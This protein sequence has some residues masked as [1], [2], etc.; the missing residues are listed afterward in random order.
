MDLIQSDRLVNRRY[1]Q[2]PK[3]QTKLLEGDGA[4][5][6]NLESSPQGLLN[7]PNQILNDIKGF[8][9]RKLA[10][11]ASTQESSATKEAISSK[12]DDVAAATPNAQEPAS[13]PPPNTQDG[14][15]I[16]WSDSNHGEADDPAEEAPRKKTLATKPLSPPPKHDSPVLPSAPREDEGGSQLH[17]AVPSSSIGNDDD[18]EIEPPGHLS[19]EIDFPVNRGALRAISSS[20]PEPTPPSAQIPTATVASTIQTG[21]SSKSRTS[22]ETASAAQDDVLKNAAIAALG[23]SKW[24]STALD[25]NQKSSTTTTSSGPK[26]ASEK[27]SQTSL[28]PSA[29]PNPSE[30]KSKSS[31]FTATWEGRRGTMPSPHLT[32]MGILGPSCG[33]VPPNAQRAQHGVA[34][35]TPY[36]EFKAAYS[37]YPESARKFVTGC[38]GVKQVMLDRAL[39][40]FL[41]DD[42]V[43]VYTTDFLLYVSE[44]NRKK[45]RKI[46]PA[47][48]WYNKFVK[49]PQYMKKIIRKDN[50]EAI[51]EAHSDDVRAIKRSFGGSQSTDSDVVI[52]DSDEE[53]LDASVEEATN[54]EDSEF[55][56]AHESQPS[57]E[58]HLESPKVTPIRKASTHGHDRSRADREKALGV[59]DSL[60]GLKATSNSNIQSKRSPVERLK[61]HKDKSLQQ[62]PDQPPSSSRA[63]VKSASGG[64]KVASARSQVSDVTPRASKTPITTRKLRSTSARTV[65]SSSGGSIATISPIQRRQLPASSP[66]EVRNRPSE[67]PSRSG[68]QQPNLPADHMPHQSEHVMSSSRKRPLASAINEADDEDEDDDAFDPPVNKLMPPPPKRP[69]TCSRNPRLSDPLAVVNMTPPSKWASSPAASTAAGVRDRKSFPSTMPTIST[70]KTPIVAP[71]TVSASSGLSGKGKGQVQVQVQT[72]TPSSSRPNISTAV[73]QNRIVSATLSSERKL[74]SNSASRPMKQQP[75]TFEDPAARA[76]RLKKF[77]RRRSLG[78]PSSSAATR[79]E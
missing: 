35:L 11:L 10:K 27:A 45:R 50:L 59:F 51:L 1:I 67:T 48:Q 74:D 13:S 46:L 61:T 63:H 43:R 78:T 5:Y 47:V 79:K 4:W 29:A 21:H 14:E 9:I 34:N 73:A 17:S 42:Y 37:D 66:Q 69:A 75:T 40:E 31:D 6:D 36:E 23:H 16:D 24:G 26:S 3:D 28:N 68:Q 7:P 41:Y 55:E 65:T 62:T 64:G 44:C 57:P 39:P 15:P 72:K 60:T 2:V 77:L 53:M 70:T 22:N 32:E 52:E 8:H 25:V 19:Q 20:R 58:L 33:S 71:R 30:S 12:L 38:L 56:V 54:E 76:E 49:D 18:L